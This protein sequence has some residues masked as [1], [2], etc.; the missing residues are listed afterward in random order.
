MDETASRY[1]TLLEISESI[2]SHS[3]FS[4]FFQGLSRA[5]SRVISFNGMGVSLCDKEQRTTRLY[6]VETGGPNEMPVGQVFPLEQ[7]PIAEV[8]RTRR[9]FYVSDVEVETRFP[10]INSLL[11][12][13]GV[14]SYCV[15]LLA[16]ARRELG[17]LHFGSS[18]RDA[19]AAEDIIFM[20]KV[21]GQL[22]VALENV[23][24]YESAVAY[25]QDLARDRDHL[26]LLLQVNRAVAA[27][28]DTRELFSAISL[29]LR[30]ALGVEYASLT[31]LDTDTNR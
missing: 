8:L 2:G 3:Q 6:L 18:V 26:Q 24:N 12:R 20:Q 1:Q 16:T 30:Q 25:Q 10:G 21:A 27:K 19:Y 14:R 23:L 5:L 15:L 22:A 17:G 28:L 4:E 29:C 31:L 7:A 13:H 9:P 11:R